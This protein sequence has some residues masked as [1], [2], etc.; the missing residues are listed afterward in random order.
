MTKKWVQI[1]DSQAKVVKEYNVIISTLY[2]GIL[3]L[4]LSVLSYYLI[5]LFIFLPS[6]LVDPLIQFIESKLNPSY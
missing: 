2:I 5:I 4:L 6:S 1:S 3:A